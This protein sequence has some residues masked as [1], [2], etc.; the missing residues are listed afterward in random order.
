MRTKYTLCICFTLIIFHTKAQQAWFRTDTT[1]VLI[2]NGKAALNPWAGGLNACQFSTMHLNNDAVLDL[3]VFDRTNGKVTTFLAKEGVSGKMG[4]VHTPYFEAFFPTIQNWM[5]L[6]DYDADGSRDLFTSTPLG[7]AVY[8]QVR[9]RNSWSWVLKRNALYTEGLST[10]INLQVSGADIPGIVDIDRDGDLDVIT[11]D[12]SGNIIELH[13]NLSVERYGVVD[14][15]GTPANPVFKRNGEC[16]GNFTKNDLETGFVF[17]VDCGVADLRN[18][19]VLHSGNSIFLH[20]MNGDGSMDLL[21]GHISSENISLINNSAT[22]IVANFT[23]STER[24]PAVDP[25]S[26]HIFPAVFMED[27]DFDGVKDLIASTNVASSDNNLTNF[28]S[29]N[30]YYHN[31]GATENPV[32]SLVQKDF[33]QDQMLDVGENAAPCFVDIDGDGDLDMIVGTGGIPGTNGFRGALWLLTN[34]GTTVS[35]RFE[36]TSENYLSLPGTYDAYNFRPQWADFNGDGVK[37]LGF[38]MVSSR[39]TEFRYLPNKAKNGQ[40]VQ[41]NLTEAVTMA[42][43]AE[44][45]S[46]DSPY[47][48]DADHDGDLDLLVGKSQGNIAFYTN[49]GTVAKPVFKMETEAFAGV[50]M[51]FEG[52]LA[53]VSVADIDLDGRPDLLTVDQS[54]ILRIFHSGEWGKWTKRENLLIERDG[55]GNTKFFGNYL[56]MAVADYNGDGKPDIAIGGNQGGVQ[57]TTNILPVT[58]TGTEPTVDQTFNVYPNPAG[59]FIRVVSQRNAVVNVYSVNGVLIERD[60]PVVPN[61]ENEFSTRNWTPGL[62]IVELRKGAFSQTKKIVVR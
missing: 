34:T 2:K 22:G 48:Y 11:F 10:S 32:F 27:V 55:K 3:V 54:G 25:V 5:I 16:W 26:F 15:L 33:L 8:Q 41:F 17:G 19:R 30:W 60:L 14:S 12:F 40:A 39:G 20:D 45:T 53:Q 62:Y 7:I 29:S 49:T 44:M 43:P 6:A 51:N 38:A 46:G 58:I 36:L 47:F 18:A 52:R 4:Y 21:V 37:D 57:L 61:Q 42:L 23:S 35:P 1:T 56:F 28:R 13:Q 31:S 9:S 50:G 24:F 59:Q